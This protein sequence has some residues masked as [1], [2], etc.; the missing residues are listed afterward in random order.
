MKEQSIDE[1]KIGNLTVKVYQ[2]FYP[3]DPRKEFDNAGNM[4]FFH[5][6]YDIGDKHSF[7]DSDDF[8]EWWTENGKNGVIMDVYMYDHSGISFSLKPFSC[9][10]DSGQIGWIYITADEIRKIYSTKRI[11]K[12][13]REKAEN[14]LRSEVE[15]YN[16]CVTG[17][18]YGFVVED[19]NGEHVD[20]CWGFFGDYEYC[21]DE[22]ISSAKWNIKKEISDHTKQV[23][24]WIINKVPVQYRFP[25]PVKS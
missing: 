14:L 2:D 17:N 15:T 12:K 8:R 25:C 11:T 7:P 18:V 10:W 6:R 20:S 3:M 16:D 1:K 19:E 21:M 23:K 24:S 4:V 22:G 9:Q 5:S 13:I